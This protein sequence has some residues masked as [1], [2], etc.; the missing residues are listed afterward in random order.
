MYTY[1]GGFMLGEITFYD[2][3]GYVRFDPPEYNMILGQ[4][5]IIDTDRQ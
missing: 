3:A 4:K 1:D 5:L 2:A